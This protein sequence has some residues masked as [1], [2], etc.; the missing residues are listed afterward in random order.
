MSEL[1]YIKY[2]FFERKGLNQDPTWQE[3]LQMATNAG[4]L[5]ADI[6]QLFAVLNVPQPAW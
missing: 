3:T 2:D 5:E 6:A 4:V 1:A